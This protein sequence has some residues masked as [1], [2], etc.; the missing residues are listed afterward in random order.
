M[1]KVI[2]IIY[3]IIGIGILG[4]WMMLL[5]TNQVPELETEPAAIILHIIIEVIMG[6]ACII[7]GIVQLKKWQYRKETLLLT[8]GMV[9]YSVVNSSGYYINLNSYGMVVFFAFILLF[10]V[11]SVHIFT[12]KER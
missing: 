4:L 9:L 7:T 2:S 8:T 10:S 1:K 6:V 3:I 11:Y 5:L 12:T